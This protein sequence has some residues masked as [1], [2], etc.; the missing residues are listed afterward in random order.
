MKKVLLVLGLL[1][2][3]LRGQ[4]RAALDRV[5][6]ALH[7][8]Q[9]CAEMVAEA[10]RRFV[11]GILKD[12]S[13]VWFSAD[14]CWMLVTVVALA[15]LVWWVLRSLHL[16]ASRR[17]ALR[18]GAKG[19]DDPI[20]EESEDKLG[21]GEYVASLYHLITSA[22]DGTSQVVGVYGE[23][24]AGKTSAV[25]LLQS[26]FRNEKT[27]NVRFT[28]F[29]PWSSITRKNIQAE[30]FKSI[31]DHLRWRVNPVLSFNFLRYAC[32][33]AE[34]LIPQPY[35][36]SEWVLVIA[37]KVFNL[38]SSLDDVKRDLR[39]AL[40]RISGRIVVVLDDLD[41]L[42]PGELREIIRC[43]KT[44]GD[45]PNVTYLLLT[46]EKRL[47]RATAELYGE[48]VAGE[49][50]GVNFLEKIVQYPVPLWNVPQDCLEEEAGRLVSECLRNNH[51]SEFELDG[52]DIQFCLEKFSTL[53]SVKRL[54]L[55]FEANL[56]YYRA[57]V[58]PGASLN[59]HLGDALRLTALRMVAPAAVS[60][61]YSWYK[62]WYVTSQNLLFTFGAEKDQT[63]Y[64]KLL[65][66][67]PKPHREWFKK[68]V[69]ETMMISVKQDGRTYI[70]DA[71][72]DDSAQTSF[73]LASPSHF[74][75]Y[76]HRHDLPPSLF[77]KE[78]FDEFISVIRD[79][80]LFDE[81]FEKTSRVYGMNA[82]L[83]RILSWDYPFSAFPFKKL[84]IFLCQLVDAVYG[85]SK[86][87]AEER[88]C[89][90]NRGSFLYGRHLD[91]CKSRTY[92]PE[93]EFNELADYVISK[94]NYLV[95]EFMILASVVQI[96]PE[97]HVDSMRCSLE[98]AGKTWTWLKER[99][100][101]KI[102]SDEIEGR[103]DFDAVA[104]YYNLILFRKCA[105]DLDLFMDH[106]RYLKNGM[107]FPHI[108]NRIKTLGM[109]VDSDGTAGRYIVFKEAMGLAY[110]QHA[111]EIVSEAEKALMEHFDEIQHSD[112]QLI[113]RFLMGFSDGTSG[114]L[115]ELL[116]K[117]YEESQ[118]SGSMNE[119]DPKTNGRS[120]A[121]ESLRSKERR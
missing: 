46:D 62:D 49:P 36:L 119:A 18:I 82:F 87:D 64:D 106:I 103:P 31:G 72:K 109:Y 108:V 99:L 104:R 47:A 120:E 28:W 117:A 13:S 7:K 118:K 107:V 93:K 88:A 76:F 27:S 22:R 58:K 10:D 15:L 30:L 100:V 19:F 8:C 21:R 59:L 43:V 102:F 1:C 111:G 113:R 6:A 3:V 9:S 52:K 25:Q 4:L 40:E 32:Q 48:G 121:M 75:R 68:F 67:S 77:P 94:E 38:F 97:V 84:G 50:E 70:P 86:L 63:S 60:E 115:D 2:Y 114:K 89:L 101:Q 80:S 71:F 17:F 90:V 41:R 56:A 65:E 11:S 45:L 12:D 26:K 92:V 54:V 23:W 96:D 61:L 34:S 81:W 98:A 44:N 14:T 5:F 55:T 53:R 37:A 78:V 35:G 20:A 39:D 57:A 85:D 51:L 112:H 24:G 66:T 73:R 95:A 74:E 116:H 105:T 79:P 110:M 16:W 83:R 33:K 91:R 42:E 29:N 69:N